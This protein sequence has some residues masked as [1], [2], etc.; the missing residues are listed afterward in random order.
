MK[1]STFAVLVAVLF[2]AIAITVWSGS[3]RDAAAPLPVSSGPQLHPT[4]TDP[5][6][7]RIAALTDI[8]RNCLG[9]FLK[10][11]RVRASDLTC[12]SSTGFK[13]VRRLVCITI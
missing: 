12:P 8:E 13:P 4:S 10:Y 7:A 2:A 1:L 5:I 6:D 9:M 11:D 3:G